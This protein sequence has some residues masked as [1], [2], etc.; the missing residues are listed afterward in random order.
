MPH[1]ASP[2]ADSVG[3]YILNLDAAT[4]RWAFMEAAFRPTAFRIHR[5][6]AVNGNSLE[7]PIAEFAE[8][9]YR[10]YHGRS[11]NPREVGCYLSHIRACEA[12]LRS[13]QQHALICEDDIILQ[14]HFEAVLDAALRHA[15]S[16][17]VLRLSG[18][19]N[20]T[21]VRVASLTEGHALHVSLGRLKGAGAYIVDRAA[22]AAF[23][24]KLLPMWLPYDHAMDREWFYGLRAAVVLPFPVSQ[25]ES[26]FR[27]SIQAGKSRQLGKLRRW[28]TTY[29]YQAFN[30]ISRWIF[31]GL[32]CAIARLRLRREG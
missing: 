29:P 22:A 3:V 6:P 17:N 5:V 28:F 24:A 10:W 14:P 30:E 18:L 9:D 13:D 11:T 26:G 19:S 21:P 12:F 1:F 15:G 7:L 2:R 25:T 20:G 8:G 31:R 27:S 4:D 16:W 23:A 32:H